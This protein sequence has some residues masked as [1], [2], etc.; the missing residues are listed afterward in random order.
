MELSS[1]TIVSLSLAVFEKNMTRTRQA[2]AR[3]YVAARKQF[4][5][6]GVCT[7]ARL[8]EIEPALD[9]LTNVIDKAS[10][11]WLVWL[12]NDTDLDPLR[13]SPRFVELVRKA[14]AKY[15]SAIPSG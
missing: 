8:R 3:I 14:K 1:G 12:D 13:D 5:S 7:L 15:A 9:L 11:G 4:H 10:Q 2:P 6:C